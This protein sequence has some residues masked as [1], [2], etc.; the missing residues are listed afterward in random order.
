MAW[1]PHGDT[2]AEKARCG[3]GVIIAHYDALCKRSGVSWFDCKLW[4]DAEL[5]RDRGDDAAWKYG[6]EE[7][8]C[9][10]PR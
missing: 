9:G 6:D 7:D 8:G 10:A 2:I 3:N 4:R 5:R 1:I